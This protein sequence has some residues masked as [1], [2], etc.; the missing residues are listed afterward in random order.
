MTRATAVRAPAGATRATRAT[1]A[2]EDAGLRVT[3]QRIAI[4]TSLERAGRPLTAQA[5]HARLHRGGRGGP[6]LA[7]VY[8]T[9]QA[10]AQG[11]W[12]RTF[13]SGEGELAYRLCT[14]GHHH[15]LICEGCGE[16]VELPACGIE[17]WA[18]AAAR[19]EGFTMSSHQ[20]D[21]FGR[22]RRCA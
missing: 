13:P 6:G 8:R 15:H 22:C 4:V 10:L 2:L 11:G 12:A 16:V 5:L 17:G 9:L 7:T 19:G 1:R 3:A 14:P 21:V 18:A 20:A